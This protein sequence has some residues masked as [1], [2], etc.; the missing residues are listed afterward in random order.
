MLILNGKNILGKFIDIKKVNVFLGNICLSGAKVGPEVKR[1]VLIGWMPLKDV[2]SLLQL[3][4]C[5]LTEERN[6]GAF[7]VNS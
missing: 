6:K 7:A 4:C 2:V 1:V 3:C 5:S